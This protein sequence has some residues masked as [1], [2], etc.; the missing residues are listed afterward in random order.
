MIKKEKHY[1]FKIKYLLKIK[2]IIFIKM[3]QNNLTILCYFLY[4]NS[5][6]SYSFF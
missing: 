1:L 3:T 2:R 5:N 6:F 4:K